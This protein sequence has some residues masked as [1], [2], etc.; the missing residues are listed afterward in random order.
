MLNGA[1]VHVLLL[2]LT[3]FHL[4]V[5]TA[6]LPLSSECLQA[7]M[8][9]IDVKDGARVSMQGGAMVIC[10]SPGM[11]VESGPCVLATSPGT[12]FHANGASF[13]VP[14][15]GACVALSDSVQLRLQNCL[16]HG[17]LHKY[18]PGVGAQVQALAA[19]TGSLGGLV[20]GRWGEAQC[21]QVVGGYCRGLQITPPKH[22][23][24][25]RKEAMADQPC[26]AELVSRIGCRSISTHRVR[27]QSNANLGLPASLC[28]PPP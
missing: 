10:D 11:Q 3:A 23:A 19:S 28:A 22:P 27:L 26:T 4:A 14:G 8:A 13:A 25:G 6:T 15:R 20:G 1:L 21:R 9:G 17:W 7:R 16:L 18:H 24:F 5:R 2:V 12:R